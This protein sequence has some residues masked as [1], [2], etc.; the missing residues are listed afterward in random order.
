M[1]CGSL[2]ASLDSAASQCGFNRTGP[3]WDNDS[4]DGSKMNIGYVLTGACVAIPADCPTNYGPNQYLAGSGSLNPPSSISLD[5]TSGS[6]VITL[7]ED[8][9]QDGTLTFGYYNASDTTLGA[10]AA[11]EQPIYGPLIPNDPSAYSPASLTLTS[12]EDYGF[13]LTRC[14]AGGTGPGAAS[15]VGGYITLF[16]NASLNSCTPADPSCTTDQHFAIFT[17]TTPGIFYVGVEDWGLL[18]EPNNGEGY[19]DDNDIVF[20]LNTNT[21]APSVPE[22]A[23]FS[24]IG[25]GLAALGL[26]RLRARKNLGRA[27]SPGGS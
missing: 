21:A 22:P 27:G 17:S 4:G 20:A 9:T 1:G 3:Y 6:D 24:V 15:C 16:S 8:I 13:Y 2:G 26:A 7:L 25:A 23:T 11:S 18:G 12:G 14:A 19:G 5:H 10:A